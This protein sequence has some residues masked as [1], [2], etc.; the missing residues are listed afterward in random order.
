MASAGKG[1]FSW[2]SGI[3]LAGPAGLAR[4]GSLAV[5]ITTALAVGQQLAICCLRCGSVAQSLS[6][7]QDQYE[8][9]VPVCGRRPCEEKVFLASAQ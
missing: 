3:Q 5:G 8:V 9:K 1:A 4:L 2:R 7:M 6:L